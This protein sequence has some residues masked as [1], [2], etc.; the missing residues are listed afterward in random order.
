MNLKYHFENHTKFI[1]KELTSD[2]K[3]VYQELN[4]LLLAQESISTIKH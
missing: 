1:F 4:G 2:T 3:H